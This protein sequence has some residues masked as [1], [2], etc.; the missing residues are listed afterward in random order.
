MATSSARYVDLYEY[1][2]AAEQLDYDLMGQA[3]RLMSKLS[4]YEATCREPGYQVGS[5]SL[6]SA[7]RSY[8]A[9]ALPVDQRVR[10]VGE[11]FQR[12]DG[13]AETFLGRL[14]Q[15]SIGSIL[16]RL[17]RPGRVLAATDGPPRRYQVQPGETLS[18]IAKRFG[19]TVEDIVR[20]NAIANR[21]LIYPGQSLVI[22]GV[23]PPEPT[24]IPRPV[25]T[26]GPPPK[27]FDGIKGKPGWIGGQVGK[28]KDWLNDLISRPAPEQKPQEK[29]QNPDVIKVKPIVINSVPIEPKQPKYGKLFEGGSTK[30]TGGA[31]RNDE[32]KGKGIAVDIGQVGEPAPTVHSLFGGKVIGKGWDEDGYGHYIKIL[33][34]DG[35]VVLY[36][37]LA[38]ASA[39]NKGDPINAGGKIGKMGST[40]KSSGPHLHI[41]FR[42]PRYD[43]QGNYS[44]D[45]PDFPTEWETGKFDPIDYL[46]QR[47]VAI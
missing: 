44:D 43:E 27:L 33:Q 30:L 32:G 16:F 8:A 40:G 15:L 20:E 42:K 23:R 6:G 17:I 29:P 25:P 18:E 36:A 22:P 5:D 39:L 4:Y 7:L 31:H 10:T 38:E 11:A 47:G 1:A 34:E 28:L 13:R 41:E 9:H 2:R 14:A 12:A 46:R 35:T 3:D 26:P 24:P 45:D 19:I 37:H 21:N